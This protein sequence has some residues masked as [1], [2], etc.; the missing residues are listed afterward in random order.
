MT[1]GERLGVL[2]SRPWWIGVGV[3]LA[4]AVALVGYLLASGGSSS[5]SVVKNTVDGNCS[6]AGNNNT[7]ICDSPTARTTP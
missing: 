5:T 3:I 6:I 1:F 4:T 7:Q 2:L